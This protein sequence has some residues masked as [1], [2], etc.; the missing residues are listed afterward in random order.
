[1]LT[2][3]GHQIDTAQ[4]LIADALGMAS[5]DLEAARRAFE[6]GNIEA[7]RRAHEV[8]ACSEP[9]H[10]GGESV[11]EKCFVFSGL[12][13]LIT[14][15]VLLIVCTLGG[16]NRVSAVALTITALTVLAAGFGARDYIRFALDSQHYRRE[17]RREQWEMDNDPE[18]EQKEMEEILLARGVS[19]EDAERSMGSLAKYPSVFVDL[20]MVLELRLMWP[21][22]SPWVC[23]LAT[24]AATLL[25]GAVPL[26]VFASWP[27]LLNL[28]RATQVHSWISTHAV[29][30]PGMGYVMG[31]GEEAYMVLTI[32]IVAA[33]VH[34]CARHAILPSRRRLWSHA[35]TLFSVCAI[36]ALAFAVHHAAQ[37]VAEM[38]VAAA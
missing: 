31:A 36:A 4:H 28:F 7:S 35:V 8:I 6:A 29:S 15:T 21:D 5:R 10:D 26:A 3:R 33:V 16:L 18:G 30:V 37:A 17:R 32:A 11:H 1:V 20:M 38:L 24:C 14:S 22:F 19:Q 13:G 34:G 27:R 25:F 12:D 23:G 2:A 9:G